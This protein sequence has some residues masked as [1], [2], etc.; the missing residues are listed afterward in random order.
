MNAA[1]KRNDREFIDDR[2]ERLEKLAKKNRKIQKQRKKKLCAFYTLS[3]YFISLLLIFL[4]IFTLINRN[5]SIS[6]KKNELNIL[7]EEYN[8]KVLE[9]EELRSEIDN[10]L[11]LAMVEEKAIK[12][13]GLQYP[14]PE[15]IVYIKNEWQYSLNETDK[16]YA[17][18]INDSEMISNNTKGVY[19]E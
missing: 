12:E 17:K 15:Q 3:L 2:S 1:R 13:L 16:N 4:M 14:K 8:Q 5:Y 11:N 18:V 6:H 9:K 19:H 10:Y 7:V